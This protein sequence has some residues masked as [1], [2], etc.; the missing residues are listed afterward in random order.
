[1]PTYLLS[2]PVPAGSPG[3]STWTDST[4]VPTSPTGPAGGDLTG[5]YPNPTVDGLQGQPI[6]AVAPVN[7][8]ILT[9]TAGQWTPTTPPAA[10]LLFQGTWDASTGLPPVPAA[11]TAGEAWVVNV[12]GNTNLGGITDWQVGDWAVFGGGA[13]WFKLDNTSWDTT[14]NVVGAS[15]F[16]GSTNAADV[17]LK[18]NNITQLTLSGSGLL[19]ATGLDMANNLITNIGSAGT[20]FTAGGGLTLASTLTVSAGGASITGATTV[21]TG[22]GNLTVSSAG[23]STINLGS[24]NLTLGAGVYSLGV[25]TWNIASQ[26]IT[27]T[28][29]LSFSGA[30]IVLTPTNAL[31]VRDAKQLRLYEPSGSGTEYTSFRAQA[32]GASIDY[33]LPAAQGAA[34]TFLRNDGAGNLSWAAAGLSFFTEA[35]S[36]AVPNNTVYANSLTAVAAVADADFV[37]TPKGTGALLAETPDGVVAG[38]DKRGA[39]ATDWQRIRTTSAKVASGQYSVIGGGSDNLSSGTGAVVAGGDTN[40]SSQNHATVGG[41]FTNTASGT[42]AFVGGGSRNTASGNFATIGGG[43]STVAGSGN[44]ATAFAATVAGGENNDATG[45]YAFIGGGIG[46]TANAQSAIVVGGEACTASGTQS[47]VAGGASNTA[48]ASYSAISGGQ[49]HFIIAG[50]THSVIGGG[51][52]NQI[53]TSGTHGVVCGGNTNTVS[54]GSAAIV[55]GSTNTASGTGAFIGAGSNHIAS[56][57]YS[58]ICGGSLGTAATRNNTSGPYSFIGSGHTN[59]INP[60]GETSAIV[61]GLQNT[62]NWSRSFIGAGAANTINGGAS[63][64]AIVSGLTNVLTANAANSFIGGGEANTVDSRYG[65]IPGGAQAYTRYRGELAHANGSFSGTSSG[66]AQNSFLVLRRAVT[67]ALGTTELTFDDAAP[68]TTNTITLTNNSMLQF[69]VKVSA[70]DNNTAGQFAWWNITGG[71]G[72]SATDVT[73]TLVGVNVTDTGNSGGNSAGWTCVVTADATA[74]NGR[75]RIQVSTPASGG[76][77]RFVASVYLTRSA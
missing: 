27:A 18:R 35:Q 65:S 70:R 77:V 9:Y 76:T 58:V 2:T 48:Q 7:G 20:D 41:G 68:T 38:G 42:Y 47:L 16:I 19:A 3:Q 13:T 21:V 12:A 11:T 37:I 75:M 14:G 36:T 64:S 26:T 15:Q 72:R 56:G 17:V 73:T 1:M 60:N 63:E 61:A 66:D 52:S 4:L 34:S 54:A 30:D 10:P 25:G 49:N 32:Q 24:T 6:S 31:E 22:I 29:N 57:N 69:T 50:R 55:G 43:G 62:I 23:L 40:I 39:N 46:N 67:V 71:I 45:Q 74:G 33:V 5:T 59:L 8:Q 51:Q 28:G 53:I 44:T